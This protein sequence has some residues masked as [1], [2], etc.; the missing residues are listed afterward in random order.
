[1]F[2]KIIA[3]EVPAHFVWSDEKVVAFLSVAPFSFGHVLVVPR[4][5][6]DQWVSVSSELLMHVMVVAQ[7]IGRVQQQ[8]WGSSR[9]GLLVQGFEVAHMHVHVWPANSGADF[10]FSGVVVVDDLVLGE[11]AAKLRVGLLSAGYE[12]FVPV[13]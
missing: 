11:C 7:N 3:G 4:V 9:V 6:V 5:E 12:G 8:V 13:I 10:D 1:M 2:S